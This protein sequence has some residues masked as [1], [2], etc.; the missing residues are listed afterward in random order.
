MDRSYEFTGRVSLGA[1]LQEL[2][3]RWI[4]DQFTLDGIRYCSRNA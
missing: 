2:S 4:G 3:Y 1:L